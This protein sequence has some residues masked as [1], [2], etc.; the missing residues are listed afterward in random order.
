MWYTACADHHQ[1]NFFLSSLCLNRPFIPARGLQSVY[2]ALIS[3]A[4]TSACPALISDS[5]K[6]G[7]HRWLYDAG[8]GFYGCK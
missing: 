7:E 4:P 5:V 6:S 2:A 1:Q 8:A 3:A